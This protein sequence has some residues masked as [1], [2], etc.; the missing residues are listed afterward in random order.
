MADSS[1]LH[2]A[3]TADGASGRLYYLDWLRV[4]AILSVF[5]LHC[6]KIFDYQT[7]VVFNTVRSPVL[8]VFREFILLWIMPLIFVLSGA[9]V[10]LSFRT[11]GGFVK[12]KIRRLL[13]PGILVGTFVINP[14]YV[15]V[16]RL[17]SGETSAGFFRWYPQFFNGMYGFGGGNF[18]PWG[19]GTH[20]WYLQFLFIYSLMFLPL[21]LRSKGTEQSLLQRLA[22]WFEKPWALLLLFLPV[23]G[24]AAA[25]EIGGLGGVRMTGNWDFVSYMFFFLYGYLVFSNP[26]VLASVRKH[27][28]IYLGVAVVLSAFHLA[29]HFGVFIKIPGVTGHDLTTGAMLPLDH[30]RFGV[31]QALRGVL[32]W[33]WVL[34]LLGLGSR[35]LNRSTRALAYA[36]EAVLPF[37]MLH[38]AVIYVVGYQVIQRGGGVAVKF[39]VIAG[40]SFVVIVTLYEILIRRVNILRVLF[41]MKRSR[42]S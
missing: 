27:C 30:L 14:P 41:G 20:I 25:F 13:I 16:E 34:S 9:A 19:M 28:V 22:S 35:F 3:D 26:A 33:F 8:S 36:N 18:A 40:I 31:V 32:A 10:Y 21:F 23:S 17:F 6:G 39:A 37:Y 24:V 38:H 11:T 4:L 5:V 7:Q 12:S 1:R 15:Y 2:G 29:S 42:S